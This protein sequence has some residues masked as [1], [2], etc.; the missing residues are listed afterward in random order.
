MLALCDA[1][2]ETGVEG[3]SGEERE[4]VGLAFEGVMVAVVIAEGLEACYAADR[5]SRTGS[6]WESAS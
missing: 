4:E 1:T 2:F 6:V 5:F 3:I